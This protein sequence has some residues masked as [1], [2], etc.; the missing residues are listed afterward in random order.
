MGR[1]SSGEKRIPI[2]VTLTE[3]TLKKLN[4]FC[5]QNYSCDR[6]KVVEEAI[7]RFLEEKGIL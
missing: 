7:K 3:E 2:S 6:S 5:K 1:K 4:D